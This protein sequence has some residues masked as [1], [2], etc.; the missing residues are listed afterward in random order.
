[1]VDTVFIYAGGGYTYT[2]YVVGLEVGQGQTPG[3][4]RRQTLQRKVAS[5]RDKRTRGGQ[6]LNTAG[7]NTTRGETAHREIPPANTP[8]T[9]SPLQEEDRGARLAEVG[10]DPRTSA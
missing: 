1:M 6:H 4:Q 7:G 10:E 3:R 8:P 2:M 5:T 9:A